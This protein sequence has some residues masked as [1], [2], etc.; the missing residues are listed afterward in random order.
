MKATD[1]RL[2]N[3][4]LNSSNET[5]IVLEISKTLVKTTPDNIHLISELKPIP[6]T[7]E[8][9]VKCGFVIAEGVFGI[10]YKH[11]EKEAF[12]I[13]EEYGV[14]YVGKK[15]YGNGLTFCIK[16]HLKHLHQLQNLYFAL[17]GEELEINL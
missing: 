13:W 8:I 15:D 3:L 11:N 2:G 5:V 14:W 6:L 17:V 12:R 7:E 9:L 1:L 4:A 10:Y 16:E